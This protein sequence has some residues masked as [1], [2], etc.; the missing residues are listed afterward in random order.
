MTD[1]VL[2]ERFLAGDVNAFNLL[3]LRWK[4][5]IYNYILRMVGNT[6]AAKDLCQMTFIRCYKQMRKLKNVDKFSPWMYRIAT[7]LCY[8]EF[9]K[10]RK[11]SSDQVDKMEQTGRAGKNSV[12]AY[13]STPTP[14]DVLHRKEIQTIL[15]RALNQIP[16]DQRVVIIM[17][18]YQGLKFTEIA[19]I[20]QLPVN[21]IKSR[22]YYGLRAL[23]KILESSKLTKEVLLHEMQ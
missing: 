7:N 1:A 17:K 9:K 21:T 22:L 23:R 11:I 10:Q 15:A 16:E 6:E 3:V 2:I 12:Q 5:P 14:E 8:D 4:K 20:M 18:Q 19:D 13:P